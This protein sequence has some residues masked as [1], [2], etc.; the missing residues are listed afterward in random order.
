M[1]TVCTTVKRQQGISHFEVKISFKGG[2]SCWTSGASELASSTVMLSS[3][4]VECKRPLDWESSWTWKMCLLFS[5]MLVDFGAPSWHNSGTSIIAFFVVGLQTM[6]KSWSSLMPSNFEY[7]CDTLS[8]Q[9]SIDSP[10]TMTPEM[11]SDCVMTSNNSCV[12]NI[13]SVV[14]LHTIDIKLCMPSYEE[15]EPQVIDISMLHHFHAPSHEECI[16]VSTSSVIKK[17]VFF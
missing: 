8:H 4:L 15:R 3:F 7:F 16:F 2:Y 17:C 11:W 14:S 6:R 1:S 12:I 13:C 9:F 5:F 10:V